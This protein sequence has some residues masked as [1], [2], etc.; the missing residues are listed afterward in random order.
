MQGGLL[1]SAPW[2]LFSPGDENF[3]FQILEGAY[4]PPVL[5]QQGHMPPM[6]QGSTRLCIQS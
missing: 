6:P 3:L 5:N 4:A 2:Q 1:A